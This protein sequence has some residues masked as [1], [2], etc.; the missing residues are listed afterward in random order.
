MASP[1]AKSHASWK[2]DTLD[3]LNRALSGTQFRLA[4]ALIQHANEGTKAIFPSQARLA[5]LLKVSSKSVERAV[6]ELVQDGWLLKARPHRHKTNHYTFNEERITE[7]RLR[8]MDE[9]DA[10]REAREQTNLS[11]PRNVR[12]HRYVGSGTDRFAGS[13]P[14][15]LTG[16]HLK[17]STVN[18]HH[19]TGTEQTKW[20]EP[21][22]GGAPSPDRDPSAIAR[23]M[24]DRIE[25]ENRQ[26]SPFLRHDKTL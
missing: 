10:W 13:D 17:G 8:Q 3:V 23:S 2:L 5:H 22:I 21:V 7:A 14:A 9:D 26:Q 16:K 12:H 6:K 11:G 18:K 20:E 15:V 24:L 1:H 19:I 25:R 4:Y